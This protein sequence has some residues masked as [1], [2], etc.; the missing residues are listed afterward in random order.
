M[1]QIAKLPTRGCP[2]VKFKFRHASTL[3]EGHLGQRWGIWDP[4][5]THN[6]CFR[7]KKSTSLNPMSLNPKVVTASSYI[8]Q[9]LFLGFTSS[10]FFLFA[11]RLPSCLFGEELSTVTWGLALV[12]VARGGVTVQCG[13]WWPFLPSQFHSVSGPIFLTSYYFCFLIK[14]DVI[15]LSKW[16]LLLKFHQQSNRKSQQAPYR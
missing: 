9:H 15:I 3:G 5:G 1:T 4:M 14:G 13:V 8:T 12:C 10:V 6:N 7:R 11:R 16:F 2:W